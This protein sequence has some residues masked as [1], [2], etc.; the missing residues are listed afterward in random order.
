ME[1]ACSTDISNGN[2]LAGVSSSSANE[3]VRRFRDRADLFLML[4]QGLRDIIANFQVE[5]KA[6][7]LQ[8][9]ANSTYCVSQ[10]LTSVQSTSGSNLGLDS[11]ECSSTPPKTTSGIDYR[12]MN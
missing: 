8:S 3:G 10:L 6:L 5:Q 11:C 7:C 1:S 9:T 4:L 2:V 12:A